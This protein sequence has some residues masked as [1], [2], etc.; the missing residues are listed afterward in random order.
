M[1]A[2][3]VSQQQDGKHE[4]NNDN[5]SQCHKHDAIFAKHTPFYET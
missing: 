3:Q 1:K 5:R 2:Q 4:E